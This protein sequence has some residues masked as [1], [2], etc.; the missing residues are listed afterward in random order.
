VAVA[1]GSQANY[2]NATVGHAPDWIGCGG[3]PKGLMTLVSYASNIRDKTEYGRFW[4]P[5]TLIAVNRDT[6]PMSFVGRWGEED[7][8][9]V[10]L[11]E[12]RS[13]KLPG[14]P[15]SPPLQG[16]WTDPM[17]TI[18]CGDYKGATPCTGAVRGAVSSAP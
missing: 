15:A 12:T 18:F 3:R 13:F 17:E 4:Y 11:A 2:P 1:E 8:M 5:K 10:K 14:A 6:P 9:D 7:R 16:S